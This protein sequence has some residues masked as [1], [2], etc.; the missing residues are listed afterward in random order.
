MPTSTWP[1][2]TPPP[3]APPATPRPPQRST[4]STPTR[5]ATSTS[6]GSGCAASPA[7]ATPGRRTS[8]T[9]DHR[10]ARRAPGAPGSI[11]RRAGGPASTRPSF[12]R[13]KRGPRRGRADRRGGAASPPPPPGARGP[14]VALPD[15]VQRRISLYAALFAA[16]APDDRHDLWVPAAIDPARLLAHPGWTPPT[17]HVNGSASGTPAFDLAWADAAAAAANDR[18]ATLS[19]ARE[20][21][22]ALPGADVV[23]SL[24]ELDARL[25][26]L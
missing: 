19:I 18:S 23:V 12:P 10:L 11:A 14:G 17:V 4:R 7:T 26:A 3:H 5:S 25:A 22:V 16:C 21:A 13:S 6:A 1:A 8:T 2:T 15:A 20:L 9:F 24:D